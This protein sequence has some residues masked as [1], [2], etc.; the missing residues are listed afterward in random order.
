MVFVYL[1]A[2]AF[3]CFVVFVLPASTDHEAFIKQ[4]QLHEL[5][6]QIKQMHEELYAN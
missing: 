6:I 1:R 3:S 5:G 2:V 4:A